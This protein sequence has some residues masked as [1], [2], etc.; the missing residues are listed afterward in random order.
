M[1]EK[2]SYRE[3]YA[4]ASSVKFSNSVYFTHHIVIKVY[5]SCSFFP[6]EWAWPVCF[7]D[8]SIYARNVWTFI[9]KLSSRFTYLS[10][11]VPCVIPL[12]L[13]TLAV[14]QTITRLESFLNV[15]WYNLYS[16]QAG[17][18]LANT[19]LTFSMRKE[20]STILYVNGG[21]A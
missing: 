19:L 13:K 14:V 7:V 6:S 16:P 11:L 9:G 5:C 12:S 2:L 21:V 15:C 3:L 18:S 20:R 4:I 8:G 10:Q 1:V 17:P